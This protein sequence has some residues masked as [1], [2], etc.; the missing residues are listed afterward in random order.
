MSDLAHRP[1]DPAPAPLPLRSEADVIRR[2]SDGPPVVSILC[3]TFQHA[4]FIE[5]AIRGFLGQDTDF[6]FEVLIR[7]DA[8]TDGTADVVRDYAAR[9][10]S[11]VRASIEPVNRYPDVRAMPELTSRAR[12]EFIAICEGD[13]YWIDP[14]KLARQVAALRARPD[15]VLAHHERVVIRDGHVT[16]EAV[17]HPQ[18]ARDWTATELGRSREPVTASVLYR[19]IDTYDGRFGTGITYGDNFLWLRLSRHGGAVFV[20]DL[21]GSVYRI[22]GGGLHSG[23]DP[24]ARVPRAAESWYWMSVWF[25]EAG[26]ADRASYC[27]MRSLHAVAHGLE[28]LGVPAR[29]VGW[30]HLL[31]QALLAR[32]RAK[33]PGAERWLAPVLRWWSAVRTASRGW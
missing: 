19:N 26:E 8:S 28:E 23:T 6:P 22:H 12:G 10:P 18:Q 31:R 3:P 33:F 15:R 11:I 27:A 4:A 2:W 13:D 30:R 14:S 24:A 32:V 21:V 17:R 16:D 25:D 7:D 29:R 20:P 1:G 5:D 9:F